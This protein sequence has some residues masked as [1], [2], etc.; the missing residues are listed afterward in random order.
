[1][2]T[3]V[4]STTTSLDAIIPEMWV[5]ESLGY[6]Q[7][8]TVAAALVRRD[9][10][11]AVARQGDTVNLSKRSALVVQSKTASTQINIAAPTQTNIAVVL[12][13]HRLAA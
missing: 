10:E 8:N 7:G 13:N 5:T 4:F 9:F 6:L 3:Q 12:A 2:P 11:N 1:M